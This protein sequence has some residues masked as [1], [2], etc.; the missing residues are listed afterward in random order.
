MTTKPK[1]DCDSKRLCVYEPSG[2]TKFFHGMLL[3]EQHLLDEQT[4]HR[5]ALRRLTRYL[6]GQGV[7]CGFEVESTA[8]MC[9]KIYPGLALDCQ[10]QVIE[11]CKPQTIDLWDECKKKMPRGCDSSATPERF[12]KYLAVRYIE[13]ADDP[14]PVLT[15]PDD[16][17]PAGA[18][19]AR[20][21]SR[22]RA[23]FCF[24]FLD[25]YDCLTSRTGAGRDSYAGGD[26]DSGTYADTGGQTSAKAGS[27]AGSEAY[28]GG[29]SDTDVD[30][31]TDA[32]ADA[33][34]TA[35]GGAGAG[36]GYAD[37]RTTPRRAPCMQ[38]SPPCPACACDCGC[39][40]DSV[41]VLALLTID[42]AK[43]TVLVGC[44]C[45]TYVPSPWQLRREAEQRH[46]ELLKKIKALGGNIA[47]RGT[48]GSAPAQAAAPARTP[49]ARQNPSR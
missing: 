49:R 21:A 29:D 3:T 46:R 9:I 11:L 12:Q 22:V 6:W 23:G 31:N 15:P 30:T 39:D 48:P 13:I 24:V 14:Q 41:V 43:K 47:A 25:D 7:V 38:Q 2:R 37:D 17:A 10:G 4:Y 45:R 18:D 16:C 26:T 20:E 36:S 33:Y 42:C 35:G 8:G 27:G 32:N 34:A 44:E 40:D 1:T 28:A 19:T 5:H